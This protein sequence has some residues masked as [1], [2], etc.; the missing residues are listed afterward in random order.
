MMYWTKTSPVGGEIKKIPEDFVVE[1]KRNDKVWTIKYGFTDSIL[2]VILAHI[3]PTLPYMVRALVIGYSVMDENIDHCARVLGA[4]KVQRYVS[5]IIPYLFPS[6]IAGSSLTILISMSQ[7]LSTLIIGGGEVITFSVLIFPFINGG[8]LTIG[9][10]YVVFF[11]MINLSLIYLLEN[12][13]KKYYDLYLI[14]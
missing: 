4:S 10:S 11:A 12:M 14:K 7:Y 2:G 1:E 6:I 9:A 13:L 5:V 3:I 8:D